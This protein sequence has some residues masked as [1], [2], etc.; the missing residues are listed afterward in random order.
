VN[1]ILAKKRMAILDPS[2]REHKKFNLEEKNFNQL[3]SND[4]EPN[5]SPSKN[6]TD[7][8]LKFEKHLQNTARFAKLNALRLKYNELLLQNGLEHRQL[9]MI[10]AKNFHL[11]EKAERFL[12]S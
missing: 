7:Y 12:M 8:M 2:R 9:S 10:N 5:F 6:Y 11:K 4:K 3:E 1:F